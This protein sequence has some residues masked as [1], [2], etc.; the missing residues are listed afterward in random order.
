MNRHSRASPLFVIPQRPIACH[1]AAPHCLSFRASPLFV[2][3]QRPIACHSAAPHCLSFR[4]AP[5]LVIPRLPIVCHSAAPHC[6]SFRSAPLLVIPQRPIACHSA[7]QRRNLLLLL[8]LPVLARHSRA[9]PEVVNPGAA[10]EVVILAQPES[11]YLSCFPYAHGFNSA[12]R[13]ENAI[14]DVPQVV[15]SAACRAR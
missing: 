8:P 5:L 12:E 3:P 14:T 7:A 6:L 11:L 4:S 9:A 10:P 13:R 1:S 15:P 2:I